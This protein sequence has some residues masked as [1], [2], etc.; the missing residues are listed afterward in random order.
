[1]SGGEIFHEM[2][3]R[4]GVKHVCESFSNALSFTKHPR[5]IR[6]SQSVILVVRFFPFSMQSTTRSISTS[7]S[8]SMNKVPVT[9]QKVMPV[10]QENPVLC[11]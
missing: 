3:L 11:L 2:M 1:M 9:W 6:I 8:P 7:F 4:L 10:L 5:L